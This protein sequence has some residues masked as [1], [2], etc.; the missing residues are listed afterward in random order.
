MVAN[1]YR[2]VIT[3]ASGWL[4]MALHDVIRR[5]QFHEI[6]DEYVFFGGSE[7]IIK[8][9]DG[10]VVKQE[11]IC[12]FKKLVKRPTILFH[13]A[14]LT[15]EKVDSLNLSD[16]VRKNSELDDE[17]F[18]YLD[19]V[20][21]ES[22]FLSSS[23]AIYKKNDSRNLIQTIEENPYGFLKAVQEKKFLDWSGNSNKKCIVAR[24]FNLSGPY[25]NKWDLYALTSFICSA[26]KKNPITIHAQSHVYRSYIYVDDLMILVLNML[27]D[28]HIQGGYRFDTAGSK[29]VE[30]S[31]LANII[32][33]T[34][35][36]DVSIHR[37]E[38]LFGADHYV[39]DRKKYLLNINR[40][41]LVEKNFYEQISLTA[42][43]IKN[44]LS[45]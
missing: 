33:K 34:L 25:V 22:I 12:N 31:D 45:I 18:N 4:G 16:Y 17:V 9:I 11:P 5:S 42:E 37:P 8:Y 44:T 39:G 19:L 7:K 15:K 32:L 43:Y 35:N 13:L 41:G 38:N 36:V 23:G 27:F 29:I 30:L 10:S 24:I 28:K 20:G 6:I 26:L 2:V 21:V 14:F 3:G 40:Y 1:N